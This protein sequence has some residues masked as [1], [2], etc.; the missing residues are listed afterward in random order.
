MPG[1]AASAGPHRIPGQVLLI[2]MQQLATVRAEFNVAVFYQ[3][4][5]YG[6]LYEVPAESFH[7]HDHVKAS[8]ADLGLTAQI[9]TEQALA[10]RCRASVAWR[11][12]TALF[13]KAGGT[14]VDASAL[15]NLST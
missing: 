1:F 2:G 3:P 5:R 14:P 6:A 7:L 10:Y 9:I 4:I 8:A 11:L 15:R 12:A 13:A